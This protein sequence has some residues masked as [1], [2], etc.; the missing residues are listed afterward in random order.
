MVWTVDDV[1]VGCVA[2][3][4]GP[5]LMVWCV[6]WGFGHSVLLYDLSK[7]DGSGYSFPHATCRFVILPASS[8]SPYSQIDNTH[9]QLDAILVPQLFP[10]ISL[11]KQTTICIALGLLLQA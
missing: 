4:K 2:A 1:V 5:A 3:S 9:C 6:G 7:G 11:H 8:S 10:G